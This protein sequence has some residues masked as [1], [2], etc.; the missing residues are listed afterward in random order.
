MANSNGRA[1]SSLVEELK[2]KPYEFSF[3]QAVKLL[4]AIY[5]NRSKL[6]ENVDPLGDVVQVKSRVYFSTPSS[7]IYAIKNLALDSLSAN[8]NNADQAQLTVNFISIASAHSPLPITYT[9]II[10]DR[11]RMRD[12]GMRDFL[13][14]FN[15]RLVSMSYAIEKKHELSLQNVLPEN[16]V[17]GEILKGIAGVLIQPLSPKSSISERSILNYVSLL[18]QKP[19]SAV[20]LE[21]I[22]RDYFNVPVKVQQ[23]IGKWQ[24]ILEE[25]K[26]CIG[27]L[28]KTYNTLGH[29]AVLGE[30]Y[31]DEEAGIHL[32]IGPLKRHNF[33]EFLPSGQ[34]YKSLLHLV[35]LYLSLEWDFALSFTVEKEVCQ[36]TNLNGKSELGWT[37]WCFSQ[38]E[39]VKKNFM[40]NVQVSESI[41]RK[42][43]GI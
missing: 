22:L 38:Q 5:P 41:Q 34:A 33:H 6:G 35:R 11:I 13:D 7:D 14:I 12:Y 31:W 25:E 30:R 40:Q 17:L 29:E 18:W 1:I 28:K 36:Q 2:E 37:S 15:H 21:Q 23:F 20:G 32:H 8:D 3:H 24:W 4:E 39:K 19:R 10:Y 43:E 9:E 26:T 42:M 27:V 16:S